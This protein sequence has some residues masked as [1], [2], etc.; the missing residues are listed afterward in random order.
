[1]AVTEYQPSTH[2]FGPVSSDFI[3]PWR[4]ALL[5]RMPEADVV[6]SED[7]IRVMVE[8]P[9]FRPEDLAIDLEGN[10]LTISGEK[11]AERTEGNDRSK[12]HLLERRFGRFTRSFVLPRDVEQ[13]RIEAR[14]E[15]GVLNVMMPKSEKAR[16]RRVE[17]R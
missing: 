8:V 3:T 12:W 4:M 9:G 11:R 5:P 13:D 10:V 17:V 16:R 7:A 14:C 2:L 1:M 15:S 6:E